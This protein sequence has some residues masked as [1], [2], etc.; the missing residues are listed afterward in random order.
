[1]RNKIIF[2]R[3]KLNSNPINLISNIEQL[4]KI[5]LN[6]IKISELE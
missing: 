1:M 6:Q 3:K 5:E 4:K 2:N